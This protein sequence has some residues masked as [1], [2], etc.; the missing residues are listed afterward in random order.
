LLAA[1]SGELDFARATVRRAL[2]GHAGMHR[3]FDRGRTLLALGRVERRARQKRAAREALEAAL[4]IFQELGARL[5]AAQAQAEL[6]RIGGR[7]PADGSLTPAE[8]R[9]A[10]LVAEGRTNRETASLLMVSEHTVDSHLRHAY[11]KLGVR[12]RAELA[13]RFAELADEASERSR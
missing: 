3:P 1:A 11:R 8:R 9:V 2:A 6:A 4:A 12:S 7:P 10:E 5:W 13:R